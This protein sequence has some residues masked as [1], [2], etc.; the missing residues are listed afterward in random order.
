MPIYYA[1]CYKNDAEVASFGF[2]VTYKE[3]ITKILERV[4]PS[5][6]K[7]TIREYHNNIHLYRYKQSRAISY[8]LFVITDTEYPEKLVFD[9]ILVEVLKKALLGNTDL[10]K[11]LTDKVNYWNLNDP[12]KENARPSN[13]KSSVPNTTQQNAHDKPSSSSEKKAQ[14]ANF[15]NQ[16]SW[17]DWTVEII[18]VGYFND[19]E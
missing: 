19:T 16:S 3:T 15:R 1:A 13:D 11:Y 5:N 18:S 9:N 14:S 8:L 4:P 7:E 10:N 2:K 17:W 12:S 6:N